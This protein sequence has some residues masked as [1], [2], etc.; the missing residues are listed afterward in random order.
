MQGATSSWPLHARDKLRALNSLDADAR[1]IDIGVDCE[2]WSFWVRDDGVGIDRKGFDVLAGGAEVGRY[3]TSKA[4]T[5][6]S[7]D[8]VS[9][10]G[11]RGEETFALAFPHISFSLENTPFRHLYGKALAEHIDEINEAFDEE[12]ETSLPRSNTRRSPRKTEKKPAYVLK[13]SIPPQHVD[14]C[15]EPA[16]TVVQLQ[17]TGAVTAFLAS[18]VESF[19]I[20]HGFVAQRI[21]QRNDSSCRTLQTDM[22]PPRKRRR[23]TLSTK[24]S[25]EQDTVRPGSPSFRGAIEGLRVATTALPLTANPTEDDDAP[26]QTTWTNPDTGEIFVVDTR[27]GNS[28]P[29]HNQQQ[30][31]L[32]LHRRR[33][34]AIKP[35]T[36]ISSSKGGEDLEGI[37][38]MPDWIRTALQT[39]EAYAIP[40]PRIPA[41]PHLAAFSA[42]AHG[43]HHSLNTGGPFTQRGMQHGNWLDI[44]SQPTRPG[45]FSRTA[46]RSAR[47][48]T[49]VDRKF[50]AC[51]LDTGEDDSDVEVDTQR[52]G[53]ALVL[54]D[55]HAADERIRVERF[56]KDLCL[57]FLHHRYSPGG[58]EDCIRVD[59]LETPV[60]ILLTCHEA[61]MLTVEHTRI[62][63]ERWGVNFAGL[64][65]LQFEHQ[66]S[67]QG[68]PLGETN[69]ERDYM[70]VMVAGIPHIVSEKL[71]AG[72][73]LKNLVK[74]YLAKLE[75]EGIPVLAPTP[76]S[77]Q[78][79]LQGD[80]QDDDESWQRAMRW[81]PRELLELVNSKAC[82]GED[83][84]VR[85]LARS[86]FFF[87]V[88]SCSMIRS[89]WSN[90]RAWCKIL[91]ALRYPFS[92]RTEDLGVSE[93]TVGDTHNERCSHARSRPIDWCRLR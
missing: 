19:L 51:V 67:G 20:R 30:G 2:D 32:P 93:D 54:I 91:Q 3:G 83:T 41:L 77:T 47:V 92:A 69:M 48:M 58:S 73:E 18:V 46:L 24:R 42:N 10:F 75:A 13:L 43:C 62:A 88:P 72:D 81:C 86:S 33:T 40:E 16:K 7:L 56:L 55:Q 25:H 84:L 87:E 57:G 26:A 14:N 66:D 27:T 35:S 36:R 44:G 49:Q 11:F 31:R 80:L 53:R 38:D 8:Q 4:Y 5:P 17:N 63:F 60:P 28:Y 76:S 1:H 45:R 39:N 79:V 15:V 82:R 12:G 21:R 65:Q 23:V 34:I 6:A 22:H 71:L 89:R 85:D 9:T 61:R 50:V 74:G 29:A 37:E 68:F 59:V 52:P 78:G 64:E 70:Q 90:A